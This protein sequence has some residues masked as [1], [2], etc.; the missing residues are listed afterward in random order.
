M[1]VWSFHHNAITSFSEIVYH[2]FCL[3]LLMVV[4]TMTE[5]LDEKGTLD[6]HKFPTDMPIGL[7]NNSNLAKQVINE[8]AEKCGFSIIFRTSIMPGNQKKGRRRQICCDRF[9]FYQH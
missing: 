2:Y 4:C 6:Y 9:G 5:V 8:S 7:C 3:L 1:T